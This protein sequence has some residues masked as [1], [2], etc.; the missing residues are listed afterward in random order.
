MF[1]R[2]KTRSFKI[3]NVKIGGNAPVSVQS[4]T[5][6]KTEDIQST[7]KQIKELA[8]AGCEI[9]RCAVPNQNAA[10][11]FAKIA[12]KSP[13]PL[14][15]DIHFDHNLAIFCAKNG[16]NAIRIN[17]GN[18]KN[19]DAVAKI[20][21]ACGDAGI[22]IRVGSNSG[23]L[24]AIFAKKIREESDEEK[25][26]NLT[27][28]ALVESAVEQCHLLEKYKFK[29][30]KVSLKSSD[31]PTTVLAY[32][33]F[34]QKYD[35]PLHIGITE[36]GGLQRGVIKSTAGIA[37][38]LLEGIGNTIRVSLTADP[39]EEVKTAIIILE[40]VKLREARPEIISCPT[41]GRTQVNL[42]N[43]LHIVESR[44]DN[45]KNKAK[46]FNAA[47][48]AI[49]GCAV[50]GPGEA[51]DAEIGI[52]GADNSQLVIFKKGKI[53]GTYSE[54]EGIKAFLKLLDTLIT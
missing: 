31:V 42:E 7:L 46:K 27:A 8:K 3:G 1:T 53:I 41:C 52:S 32:R 10:K 29:D 38:L 25:K 4:M 16:A 12:T 26:R 43:L 54:E 48:I 6:T 11:A 50:N 13:I 37:A 45:L 30:I 24:S 49:M 22:P 20:A 47:K 14:V 21:N 36:A 44:I 40:S 51:K 18:L 5:N 28:C 15:A 34:A 17:P 39:V 9:V 2:E 35:Y 23:S 19:S 33:L